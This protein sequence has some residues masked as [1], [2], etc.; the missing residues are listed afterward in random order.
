MK[1]LFRHLA[2]LALGLSLLLPASAQTVDPT[3]LPPVDSVFIPKVS[4]PSRDRIEVTWTIAKG[5]YLYRHRMG[6]QA[7]GGF[8]GGT[9][10]LPEGAKHHDEFFGD[11]QTYRGSVTAVLP[12]KASGDAVS[13]RIKYQGCADAGVCYPPQTRTLSV[14]LP[15]ANDGG[16]DAG[17]AALGKSLGG[18]R[19]D[20]A[21]GLIGG[22]ANAPLP[23]EQAFRFEAIAD[24]G[25]RLLLRITPARGYYL[26]RDKLKLKLSGDPGIHLGTP[27]LPKAKAHHDEHFGDVAVYFGETMIPVPLQRNH[28]RA[29]SVTLDAE[30]QGCQD[31]G[32]CYPVMRNRFN[33]ALPAGASTQQTKAVA[34]EPAQTAIS[35]AAADGA[36]TT[37]DAS[38]PVTNAATTNPVTT[39]P[40]ASPASVTS[41]PPSTAPANRAGLVGALLFALL[42]GIILNLM[43]CVLP[44]L[45]LKALS[46]VQGGHS[47]E[48]AKRHALFYTL[49]IL[50]A[51]AVL[52]LSVVLLQRA[53]HVA[54]WGFWLQSPW[55]VAALGL[56]I[57]ALGLSLSGLWALP[58]F[59]PQRLAAA[60]NADS[61]RGDFLTGLLAVMVATPCTGPFMVTALAY[62]LTASAAATLLVFVM[63]GLGLALPVLLIAFVPALAKRLPKPG[64]WMDT[65]KQVLAFPM[66]ITATWLLWTLANQRGA[67][68]V[69]PWGLAAIALAFALWAWPRARWGRIATVLAIALCGLAL[70][71]IARMPPPAPASVPTANADSRVQPWTPQ[72][73]AELRAQHKVVFVNMTADWC[74]TCKVNEKAVFTRDAFRQSL[75]K[76]DAVYL[77]G[78]FTN[79]DPDIAAFLKAHNAVGVPL[80]MVYPRSGAEGEL[81]QTVLTADTVD[82]ALARAA[83]R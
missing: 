56:L 27:Q 42:G 28:D 7:L 30:W 13:L 59:A 76:H 67:D 36:A 43:P 24:G 16:G 52:W 63:L 47:R 55:V 11:V 58:G 61:A 31:G 26:Y 44:V 12:G 82:A 39:S 15:A 45:S 75:E 8:E 32:I 78:D 74:I 73:L 2:A 41:A 46:L 60:S 40:L 20:A 51:M 22:Q 79:E 10:Q 6:V 80:Y 35:A 70:A 23:P 54:G 83:A 21:P 25:S 5:Y 68:V 34:S 77:V 64:A 18:A 66:Y 14:V 33:L 3:Q 4:A 57:F 69:L 9:L 17:F 49:G 65:L 50:A 72:S 1:T 71:M 48:H 62:A 81:L 37:I 29:A 19:G 38:A 53:G